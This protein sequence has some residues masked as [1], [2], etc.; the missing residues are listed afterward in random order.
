MF[1]V[2]GR[3]HG[4]L[5]KESSLCCVKVAESPLLQ[6]AISAFM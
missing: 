1:R 4:D 2:E 6:G 5:F 3:P